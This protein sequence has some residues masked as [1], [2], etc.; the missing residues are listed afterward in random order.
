MSDFINTTVPICSP[1]QYFGLY[2][3]MAIRSSSTENIV[4]GLTVIEPLNLSTTFTFNEAGKAS[5]AAVNPDNVVQSAS[6]GD[7]GAL[8]PAVGP[9]NWEKICETDNSKLLINLNGQVLPLGVVDLNWNMW[10]RAFVRSTSVA[11][12]DVI[13]FALAK[14]DAGVIS[15]ATTPVSFT[16][17]GVNGP[18]T[19]FGFSTDG[20]LEHGKVYVLVVRNM[21]NANPVLASYAKVIVAAP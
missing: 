9:P 18:D 11:D 6:T 20:P 12:G 3:W 16:V 14:V 21:S 19:M 1:D 5:V 10:A 4:R 17:K 7:W 8:I 15:P 13:Q 2:D